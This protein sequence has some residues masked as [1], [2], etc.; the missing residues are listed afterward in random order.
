MDRL[1]I[2][3][4]ITLLA[5]LMALVGG[6]IPESPGSQ[7]SYSPATSIPQPPV[8]AETSTPVTNNTGT[9]TSSSI[10]PKDGEHLS[11]QLSWHAGNK[12]IAGNLMFG[13]EIMRI[14]PY[15]GKLYASTSLWMESDPS[16]PMA[17]QLLVL[18]SPNGKWKI[19]HQF[20][21]RNLRLVSLE[22]VTFGT[23][24][25]G[26]PITPVI[27]LLAA[28]DTVGAGEAQVFSLDDN[29]GE[30]IP[31]SL[32]L[33]TST[34]A[35]TR[36]IGSHHDSVIGIDL[37]FAG[38]DVL[39]MFSG[40]YDPSVSGGIKWQ[41]SPELNIPAGERVMGFTNSGGILYC[42]TSRHIYKRMDGQKPNWREVYY[43]PQETNAT[44]I[45]GLTAVPNPSGNGEVLLFGALSAIRHIDPS[46]NYKETIELDM[47]KY[48]GNLWNTVV[49]YVLPAY[50]DFLPYTIPGT[51]EKVY[52]FGFESAYSRG[53]VQ[54]HP[55]WRVFTTH[56]AGTY[57]A[58]GSYFIRH[59]DAKNDSF[60]V[61]EV[62]D[63]TLPTLVSIR[64]IAISP[65]A[66]D[67]GQVLYFGGFDCN[68]QPSHNTG[69]IY[70]GS[71]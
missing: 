53:Q 5:L 17:C 34:Y 63:S 65:F 24:T 55:E 26:K 33:C 38:N 58:E 43:C 8:T 44:G 46:D 28:P 18:D 2:K 39:G 54:A 21:T 62:T 15:K 22:T 20:S 61:A 71:Y 36:A 32:G 56:G 66:G 3:Y 29:T 40:T 45:R 23:D 4:F 70:R 47:K 35:S 68:S 51:K 60:G 11:F 1:K 19:L 12:D 59:S 42:A 30:L 49:T 52:L 9:Y 41:N 13:T 31:M 10:I 37:V 64:T 57:A 6:C 16:I 69:W 50:N 7:P 67:M 25:A 14:L 27:M 48:L